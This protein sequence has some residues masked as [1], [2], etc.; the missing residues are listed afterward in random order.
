VTATQPDRIGVGEP[1]L[2]C[3]GLSWNLE[4]PIARLGVTLTVRRG[5][6]VIVTGRA[7]TG[8]TLLVHTLAGLQQFQ[9]GTLD[10]HLPDRTLWHGVALVPQSLA[11][12][13]ELN[14]F[15]NVGL[16]SLLR[17]RRPPP[18]IDELL[19][20]LG[21]SRL[22]NRMVDEISVGERQRTMIAR[23]L[24]TPATIVLAD[25]P[26]AH[27]DAANAEIILELLRRRAA[28]GACIIVSRD[29]GLAAGESGPAID[30]DL[31]PVG[32]Q[33]PGRISRW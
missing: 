18:G 16:P 9:A 1:L 5:E 8:K 6:V 7:G 14:V 13:G 30:L 33:P 26:T 32:D 24:A 27:Q 3:S 11:L 22:R 2:S 31:D 17:H 4:A 21:L 12:A 15:D 25:E 23:A 28:A 29:P 20:Q 10:W 19:D